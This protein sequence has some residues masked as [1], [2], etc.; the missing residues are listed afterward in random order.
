MAYPSLSNAAGHL[1]V[2]ISALV[3]QL[4]RLERD[5]GTQ[6]VLRSAPG[7]PMRP[8]PRGAALLDAFNQQPLQALLHE[9]GKPVR[10]WKPNDARRTP[11][12]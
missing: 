5:I 11:T 9:R 7:R 10:G 8:I 12:R 6:L 3:T 1:G 2:H 4:Q